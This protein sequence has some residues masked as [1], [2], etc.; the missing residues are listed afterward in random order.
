MVVGWTLS[1]FSGRIKKISKIGSILLSATSAIF[2]LH[3]TGVLKYANNNKK[4]SQFVLQVYIASCKTQTA[5][6]FELSRKLQTV[7]FLTIID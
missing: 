7:G 1:I 5:S 6:I 3:A 2:T 4:L